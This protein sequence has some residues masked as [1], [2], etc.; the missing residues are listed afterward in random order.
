MLI[1]IDAEGFEKEKLWWEHLPDSSD[2]ISD[3]YR[4]EDGELIV[5][6]YDG[7]IVLWYYDYNEKFDRYESLDMVSKI[8]VLE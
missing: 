6:D 7:Q 2:E 1:E 4:T 5:F 8:E 3:S